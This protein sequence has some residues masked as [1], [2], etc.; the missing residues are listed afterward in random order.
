MTTSRVARW[1]QL[2][3]LLCGLPLF[4]ACAEASESFSVGG[5]KYDETRF[6]QWKL[7]KSLSEISGLALDPRQRLFAH[8]DENA[9]IYQLD[10][11]EGRRV[12]KF[13]LGDPAIRGDFEGIAVAKDAFYL[14]DSTGA[15]YAAPE[16]A[17]NSTVSYRLTRTGLGE[18]CEIEGLEYEPAQDS[19][20]ILCKSPRQKALKGYITIF[21]W[22][23]EKNA[24]DN[25][26]TIQLDRN[27][28]TDWMGS[29]AFHPSGI[30]VIPESGHLLIVAARER[31]L[32]EMS[33]DGAL[34]AAF[35]LPTAKHHRQAEGIALTA[36]GDLLLADEGGGKRGRLSVYTAR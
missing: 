34:I 14:I 1:I 36:D 28:L 27:A 2:F 29:R 3:L 31:A 33:A 17:D 23:L 8:N 15:L 13:A 25:G 11:R 18:R 4:Q 26:K 21:R 7:P 5:F 20:L 12:K 30:T 22:S 19:L 10:Y 16:G 9:I 35:E 32:L 24:L 6:S